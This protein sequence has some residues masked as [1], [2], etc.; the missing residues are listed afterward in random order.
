[1]N[2]DQNPDQGASGVVVPEAVPA[3]LP[4][5]VLPSYPVAKVGSKDQD[6]LEQFVTPT[7]L[8]KVP[9]KYSSIPTV[10]SL[11]NGTTNIIL[12]EGIVDLDAAR[13]LSEG[14]PDSGLADSARATE[15]QL[16]RAA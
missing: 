1:M 12:P 7:P 3:G 14:S 10:A 2:A 13:E 11:G 16:K 4:P 9:S 15:R 8:A 6:Q 5:E